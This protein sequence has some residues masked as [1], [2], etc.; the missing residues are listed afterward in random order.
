MIHRSVEKALQ[1][2]LR[3]QYPNAKSIE[4][5]DAPHDSGCDVTLTIGEKRVA[6]EVKTTNFY[7]ALGRIVLLLKR[8]EAAY[9]VVPNEILP[10]QKVLVGMPSEIGIIGF[11]I[12]DNIIKFE[13]VRQS[14][15]YQ[16]LELPSQTL[17]ETVPQLPKRYRTSLV[18]PKALRV[19]RYLVSH[20]STTQT[21][22]ARDARVSAG[23]V[24]KVVSALVDRDLVSYRGKNLVIFDV[25]K[26]LNEI[27][28]NRSLKSLKIG[29]VHLVDAK[30]TED[31]EAKLVQICNEMR[32]KYALT[33]FSG[34]TKYI[35]YGMRY[36]SVQA[37]VDKPKVIL[38]SLSQVRQKAGEGIALEIFAVDSR[39]IIEEAKSIGGLVVCS[40]VQ[41]VLDLVSYGGVG[42]DWAVKLYEAK[43]FKE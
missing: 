6:F 38:E 2:A 21:Q 8:F 29:Q 16:L 5:V 9:L 28:W 40:A 25:W 10:S 26:L 35:G 36:D 7:Y 22:I 43:I 42:R 34:A 18:S 19:V 4:V 41:L 15:R 39:D 31:V 23:M 11:Q 1:R 13:I 17:A 33:L 32:T 3:K 20:R 27:S 24:N 37:Y 30:S 14:M 12:L